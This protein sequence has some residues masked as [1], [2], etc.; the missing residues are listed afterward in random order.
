MLVV[1][2]AISPVK[3]E[4]EIPLIHVT[5]IKVFRHDEA[6]NDEQEFQINI[7]SVRKNI[8]QVERFLHS[9][10]GFQYLEQSKYFNALIA[11]TEAVNNAII[12]GN[13]CD[14][15]KV[16]TLSA[17]VSESEITISIR[18]SGEGFDPYIIPDPRRKENLLKDGG[19]GVFLITSLVDE[20]TFV[21]LADGMQVDLLVRL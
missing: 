15:S 8:S 5:C 3:V 18:D 13:K 14:E 1:I 2:I 10:P 19:R 6:M 20:A 17:R 7:P 16:V 11:V 4:T 21:R 9:L 12:H